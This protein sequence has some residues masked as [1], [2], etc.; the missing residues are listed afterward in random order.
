ML[1]F[2]AA[3]ALA[4][5][6]AAT[7]AFAGSLQEAQRRIGTDRLAHFAGGAACSLAVE[8]AFHRDPAP[9]LS[10]A[11]LTRRYKKAKSFLFCSGLAYVKE[12]SDT[13]FDRADLAASAAGAALP[14]FEIKF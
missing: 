6:L 8:R 11:L 1:K 5:F 4:A 3:V 7:P 13:S 2:F 9:G 10:G 12:L 14:L